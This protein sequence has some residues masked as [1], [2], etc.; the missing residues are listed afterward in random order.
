ML[1]CEWAHNGHLNG[2][3]VCPLLDDS[4]DKVDDETAGALCFALFPV[5]CSPLPLGGDGIALTID[6]DAT[7]AQAR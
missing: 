5:V 3:R 1:A 2:A 7:N 6:V 4:V